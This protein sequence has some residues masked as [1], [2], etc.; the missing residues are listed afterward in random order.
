MSRGL[1]D[2]TLKI[3]VIRPHGV[4]DAEYFVPTYGTTRLLLGPPDG[5]AVAEPVLAGGHIGD[6]LPTLPADGAGPVGWHVHGPGLYGGLG[7]AEVGK[8]LPSLV[9]QQAE[10]ITNCKREREATVACCPRGRQQ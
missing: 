9:L 2:G 7:R 1:R 4:A 5:T 3:I 8:L 10:G 6:I